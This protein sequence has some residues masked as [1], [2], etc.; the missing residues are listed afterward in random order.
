MD[1]AKTEQ[2]KI[3]IG[4]FLAVAPDTLGVVV[5]HNE[6]GP[7]H[8]QI[9]S[10]SWCEVTG[11]TIT[12]DEDVVS[13]INSVIDP[14]WHQIRDHFA[15]KRFGS[16]VIE[17]DQFRLLSVSVRDYIY[18]FL[19]HQLASL[20]DVYPYAYLASEKMERIL[21][22]R[23]NVY[24]NIPR[25]GNISS[26]ELASSEEGTTDK[27]SFKFILIGDSGVGKTSLIGQFVQGKFKGDFRPTIGLNVMSHS[28]DFLTNQLQ[29]NIYDIGSQK[30]FRRV[31][32]NYYSGTNAAL[33]L[34]ALS[35]RETFNSLKAWNKELEQFTGKKIPI[36]I[37]G[38][39]SDLERQVSFEEGTEIAKE[40][41]GAYIETSALTAT[42]V[43]DVFRLICLKLI[44]DSQEK[45]G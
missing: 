18:S 2:L 7:I 6:G 26:N 40:L 13:E 9:D 17:L 45:N 10:E 28:F 4:K 33:I 3:L 1:A 24:L 29:M 16:A 19:L 41:G 34:F 11:K 35:D 22:D 23:P 5:S 44:K 39:K 31:R 32:R 36:C 8:S 20:D 38:N 25:L 14:I 30:F 12:V 27:W 37:V 43:E 15:S 21:E 42:N